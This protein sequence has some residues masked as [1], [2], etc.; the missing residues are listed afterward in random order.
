MQRIARYHVLGEVPGAKEIWIV[1][2][3]YGQLARYFLNNFEGLQEGRCIVAPEGLSR[4]YLDAEHAR[5]G[6]TWMTREDR[7]HEIEDHIAYLD[8]LCDELKSLANKDVRIN[9]LGF[10]QGVATASRWCAQGRTKLHTLVLWAGS[11]PPEFDRDALAQWK[12]NEVHTVLGDKDD[13]AEP[14]ELDKQTLRFE[15]AE[16]KVTKHLFQGG[17][18][19]DQVVLKKVIGA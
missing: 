3:G 18:K 13:Y 2:H 17:H 15:A 5:V 14:A 19:L 4:F 7:L 8:T 10:S 11:I 12:I 1:L 6:A 9:A 16:L